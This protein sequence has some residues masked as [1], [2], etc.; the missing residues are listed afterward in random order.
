MILPPAAKTGPSA[1]IF[2][3]WGGEV[4]VTKRASGFRHPASR[5]CSCCLRKHRPEKKRPGWLR[6]LVIVS[7]LRDLGGPEG[8]PPRGLS[9]EG[10]GLVVLGYDFLRV[11]R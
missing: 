9:V 3:C 8:P 11:I 10:R 6:A 4:N 5:N 1:G 7:S 2:T